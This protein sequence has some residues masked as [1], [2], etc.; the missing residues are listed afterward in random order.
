MQAAN[1][2]EQL[3]RLTLVRST[4]VTQPPAGKSLRRTDSRRY[5][6]HTIRLLELLDSD[7]LS[8]FLVLALEDNAIGTFSD[9]CLHCILVHR[10]MQ[11]IPL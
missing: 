8:R 1:A 4:V 10:R 2:V 5:G 11:F 7:E 6:L 9:N 3:L